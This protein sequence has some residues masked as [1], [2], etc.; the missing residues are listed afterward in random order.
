LK[1]EKD[2]WNPIKKKM[3]PWIDVSKMNKIYGDGSSCAI[4]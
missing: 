4:M 2:Q 3:K 1:K